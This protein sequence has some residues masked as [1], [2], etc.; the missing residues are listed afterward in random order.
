M[1][2][3][4]QFDAEKNTFTVQ[5]L[6]ASDSKEVLAEVDGFPSRRDAERFVIDWL[7]E[8]IRSSREALKEK[9]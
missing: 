1:K 5:Y 4:I 2:F 8:C 6:S 9:K 3:S 7:G